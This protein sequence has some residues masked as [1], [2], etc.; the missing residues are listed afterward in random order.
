MTALAPGLLL[1]APPLGDPNF[2]RSV[3]LLAAHGPD[4][5]FGWVLNGKS[6]MSLSELLVRA[7]VCE[8]EL[9]VDG[10][11]RQGGPVSPDQVWLVYRERDRFVEVEGEWE[12][13]AGLV[14]CASRRVLELIAE[15]GEAPELLALVGYAGWAPAQLEDE[16][17]A[18]AWLPANV[19]LSL[20]FDVPPDEVWQRAYQSLGTT[21]IAFTSRVIGSA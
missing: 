8:D 19:D 12:I 7:R 6:L 18:G 14:A 21:P 20:V 15:R 17:R 4:G 5:G 16:I 13:G 1:A 11:V 10:P 3:V 2:E 9:P